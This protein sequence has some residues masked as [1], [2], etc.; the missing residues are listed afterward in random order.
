MNPETIDL[1]HYHDGLMNVQIIPDFGLWVFTNFEGDTKVVSYEDNFFSV[2][3]M[4]K[5]YRELWKPGFTQE[6]EE[7]A[8]FDAFKK[9]LVATG[10]NEAELEDDE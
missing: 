5:A 4:L 2:V 1:T 3:D 6:Q 9:W 7:P 8:F 10:A